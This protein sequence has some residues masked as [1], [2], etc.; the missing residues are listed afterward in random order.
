M[1]TL[2]G[3]EQRQVLPWRG[4]LASV[5]LG[6]AGGVGVNLVSDMDG[7]RRLAVIL[8]GFAVLSAADWLHRQPPGVR[9]VRWASPT[10]LGLA[11]VLTLIAAI[12][13]A[14][15]AGVFTAGAVA[16]TVVAVLSPRDYFT[17]C[18]VLFGIAFIGLGVA[19]IPH[20]IAALDD[21]AGPGAAVLEFW[22]AAVAVG[23]GVGVLRRSRMIMGTAVVGFGVSCIVLGL[24]LENPA[25]GISLVV[26]GAAVICLGIAIFWVSMTGAAISNFGSGLGAIGVGTSFLLT[27]S[28]IL[29]GAFVILGAVTFALG[30]AQVSGRAGL[31]GMA[32]SAHGV[33][34]MS[35]GAV[36]LAQ[37]RIISGTAGI[38]LGL[39][40]I[41]SVEAVFPDSSPAQW[42]RDLWG[43][44]TEDQDVLQTSGANGQR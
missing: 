16:V 12:G 17:A 35:C 34:L 4:Q 32:A 24:C 30:A 11:V 42:V 37:G 18:I 40:E 22:M 39:A 21:N 44:L 36:F 9:L 25:T 33:A 14:P 19:L 43:Y 7:P 29:G 26:L 15:W 10:L 1:Q 23:L 27:S 13:P 28:A 31:I 20:G 8:A 6:L 5:F 41:G 2:E 38:G 3:G